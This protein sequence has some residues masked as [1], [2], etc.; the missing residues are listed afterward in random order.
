MVSLREDG[1]RKLRRG[2]STVE[3]VLRATEDVSKTE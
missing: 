3:E 1:L 2:V